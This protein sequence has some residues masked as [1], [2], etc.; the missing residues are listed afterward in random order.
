[1][2]IVLIHQFVFLYIYIYNFTRS[3]EKRGENMEQYIAAGQPIE[4]A[5]E[6]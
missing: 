1:M 4:H 2:Y 5:A 3:K 6:E